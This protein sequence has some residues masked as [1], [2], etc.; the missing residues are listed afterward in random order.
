MIPFN[1]KAQPKTN[2]D[3]LVY[4]SEQKILTTSGFISPK[5]TDHPKAADA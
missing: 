2:S 5:L 1:G 3:K 4:S